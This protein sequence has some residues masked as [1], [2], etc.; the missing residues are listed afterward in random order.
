MFEFS[1]PQPVYRW[2]AGQVQRTTWRA[3][4][5]EFMLHSSSGGQFVLIEQF[6]PGWRATVDGKAVP[7]ERWNR[8]FQSIQVPPGDHK[9]SFTFHSQ[10]LRLGAIISLVSLLAL[11]FLVKTRWRGQLREIPSTS[12]AR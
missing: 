12:P 8:A 9:V 7:I 1:R 6:F 10:A 2:D 11:P 4:K 3:G 5:R